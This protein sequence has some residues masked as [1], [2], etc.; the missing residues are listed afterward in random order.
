MLNPGAFSHGCPK[1]WLKSLSAPRFNA[2]RNLPLAIRIKVPVNTFPITSRCLVGSE[3]RGF[4][5]ECRAEGSFGH[6]QV[7]LSRWPSIA[8][9]GPQEKLRTNLTRPCTLTISDTPGA[10]EDKILFLIH[11]FFTAFIRIT[12]RFAARYGNH[13]RSAWG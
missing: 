6:C 7:F 10:Y 9:F 4:G 3:A 11:S 12:Q 1:S 13:L 8:G 2:P 5:H